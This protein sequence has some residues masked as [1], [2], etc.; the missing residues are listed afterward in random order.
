MYII[1]E[2][3]ICMSFGKLYLFLFSDIFLVKYN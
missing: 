1:F 2:F 3:G